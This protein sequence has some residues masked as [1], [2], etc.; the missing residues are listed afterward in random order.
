MTAGGYGWCRVTHM[1]TLHA[2]DNRSKPGQRTITAV[3]FRRVPVERALYVMITEVTC[4]GCRAILA[5]RAREEERE[6]V[7]AAV[8][9]LN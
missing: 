2:T 8:A 4:V 6:R 7:R 5:E 3:C 1:E 9:L